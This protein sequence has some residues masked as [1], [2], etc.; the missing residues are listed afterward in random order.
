MIRGKQP[1]FSIEADEAVT[2]AE[3]N[4]QPVPPRLSPFLS[5][6]ETA[7]QGQHTFLPEGGGEFLGGEAVDRVASVGDEVEDQAAAPAH[8]GD[9]RRPE[10]V[11]SSC[12]RARYAFYEVCLSTTNDYSN[13]LNL[14][15]PKQ[16]KQGSWN[17]ADS[18]G[19]RRFRSLLHGAL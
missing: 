13:G 17:H 9:S 11:G 16:S 5:V 7:G 2:S 12:A 10:E 8:A 19:H 4:I 14:T 1:V 15:K 18:H 3:T 6:Y